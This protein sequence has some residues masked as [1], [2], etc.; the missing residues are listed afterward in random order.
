MSWCLP[1]SGKCEWRNIRLFIEFI[2]R[3]FGTNYGLEKCLDVVDRKNPQPEVQVMDRISGRRMV[4]ERKNL[5]WPS[6]YVKYHRGEHVFMDE[7]IARAGQLFD[8]GPYVLRL[9]GPLN[10]NK[11]TIIGYAQA[12]AE[13]IAN[14]KQDLYGNGRIVSSRPFLWSFA[15][16]G[17]FER[18]IYGDV[19]GV[20]V[21]FWEESSMEPGVYEKGIEEIRRTLIRHL[22]SAAR[23]FS[24]H[25]D[26]L[27]ILLLSVYGEIAN[28]DILQQPLTDLSPWVRRAAM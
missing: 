23:K 10:G 1:P 21:E 4:V 28:E 16:L 8:D 13:E 18:E 3:R 20:G 15:R 22:M 26:S 19:D 7:F 6:D 27:R 17:H 11:Q 25:A 24:N 2:N 9:R 5:V 12:I 14:R